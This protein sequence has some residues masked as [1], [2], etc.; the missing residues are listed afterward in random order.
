MPSTLVVDDDAA[1]ADV[2]AYRLRKAGHDVTVARDGVA[3]L[4][5]LRAGTFDLV[6]LDLMLPRLP[7]LDVLR[8]LRR[9]ATVPVI[10]LSARDGDADQVAALDLGADDYVTK[11]FSVR[12]LI[13]RAT[14]LLRRSGYVA[15]DDAAEP[16]P[17][18]SLIID[19]GR[20]E[21]RKRGAV[22]PLSP[23]EFEL[24]VYLAR[25]G[26][27]VRSRHAILDAVWGYEFDGE[28]RTV[29]VHVHWLRRKIEDDPNQPVH[30]LTVRQYGYKF[31]PNPAGATSSAAV[32]GDQHDRLASPAVDET[33]RSRALRSS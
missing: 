21:V 15:T 32:V 1:I 33:P 27:T 18:A 26:N 3:A 13:A 31:V 12:Q 17:Q 9:E 22:I 20:H 6:I 2:V 19:V 28:S 23:K 16:E 8:V 7:G 29:D 30:L 24:L 5:A 4:E 10:V 11:P 25:H 14:A